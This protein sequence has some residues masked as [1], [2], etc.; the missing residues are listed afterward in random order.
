VK[1]LVKK[2]RILTALVLVSLVAL[3]FSVI[4]YAKPG[5][6]KNN[7]KFLDFVLHVEHTKASYANSVFRWNPPSVMDDMVEPYVQYLFATPEDAVVC[8]V[9]N[10]VWTL[11]EVEPGQEDSRYVMIGEDKITLYPG[12]FYCEY[13]VT[14]IYAGDGF[15]LYK[16]ETT[17]TINSPDYTGTIYISSVEKTVVE[18]L[19]MIGQGT[20][21]GRGII[22]DQNV[23]VSGERYVEINLAT[24]TSFAEEKGTIMGI[25]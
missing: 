16:L 20:F 13:D 10:N 2:I 4:V 18:G 9:K 8:F 25:N 1:Y 14:W 24:F 19:L 22:N 23:K 7:E 3:S 11:D 5:M 21:V 12:D 6:Q 17:L 15:G